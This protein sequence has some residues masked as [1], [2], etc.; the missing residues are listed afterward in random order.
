MHLRAVG[1]DPASADAAGLY[2]GRIRYLHVALGGAAAGAGG[3][4]LTLR[5]FSH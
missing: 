5:L 1:H 4:Y 3:G 2:V